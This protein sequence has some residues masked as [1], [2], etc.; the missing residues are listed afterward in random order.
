MTF[1]DSDGRFDTLAGSLAEGWSVVL[2]P[3][4]S[5]GH[6]VN[7]RAGANAIVCAAGAGPLPNM[8]AALAKEACKRDV[9]LSLA[10][11]TGG[12]NATGV[13]DGKEQVHV[14]MGGV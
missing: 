6:G 14:L 11:A 8:E 4:N 9:G 1:G 3:N 7:A 13:L 2:N 12:L 10:S 5:S